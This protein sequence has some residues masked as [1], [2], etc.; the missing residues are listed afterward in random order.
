MKAS[1][2][3]R[4]M[5]KYRQ[6]TQGANLNLVSLM[7]IFTILVFFLLVNS[8]ATPELPSYKDLKLPESTSEAIAGDNLTIA[9]TEEHVLVQGNG[10]A[11]MSEVRRSELDVVEELKAELT[12]LAEDYPDDIERVVT[13]AGHQDIEYAL[14]RK[15]LRT[16]QEA[17][18]NHIAF[19]ANQIQRQEVL[20]P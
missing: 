14:I 1:R 7:D 12:L 9:L 19:A 2:R 3:V 5:K 4:R 18:F 20:S 10:I 16:C 13:I 6:R 11:S 8:S 15:I 17:G